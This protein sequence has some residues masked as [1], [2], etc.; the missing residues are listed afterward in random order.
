MR[1][2]GNSFTNSLVDQLNLLASRQY[3]LQNQASSGQRIQAPED[4]PAAMQQVLNLRS[5]QQTQ[6][7]YS[8]NIAAL[9]DRANASFSA[10][11]AVHK[12]STRVGEIATLA[13]GTKA[14]ADLKNYATELTQLIRQAAD[15]LNGKQ[16]GSYLFGGTA[17][18]Q[19][20]FTVT[21]DA[22]GNVTGVTYNGN[23]SVTGADIGDGV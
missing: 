15:L 4:D 14:P 2:T 20:P 22:N 21:T 1:V 13:D 7:Q 3:R 16:N 18:G 9:K 8:H 6:Q 10:I 5:D 12:I 19:A 11:Q 17:S 23:T